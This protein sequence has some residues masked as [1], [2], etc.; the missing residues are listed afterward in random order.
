MSTIWLLSKTTFKSPCCRKNTGQHGFKKVRGVREKIFRPVPNLSFWIKIG[1]IQL[2][3][4]SVII[5]Y[6][7][8]R[9]PKERERQKG[10]KNNKT[11]ISIDFNM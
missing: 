5:K 9:N 10:K 7:Y 2:N 6:M 11:L 4:D 8:A 3:I 1:Q